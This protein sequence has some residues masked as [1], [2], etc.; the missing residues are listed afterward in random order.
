MVANKTSTR[1]HYREK[2]LPSYTFALRRHCRG[3]SRDS[4]LG[5]KF[6]FDAFR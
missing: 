6:G 2:G 3:G 4:D 1:K 5:P